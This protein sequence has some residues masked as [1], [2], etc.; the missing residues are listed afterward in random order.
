MTPEQLL[1]LAHRAERFDHVRSEHVLELLKHAEG[2]RRQVDQLRTGL[3]AAKRVMWMAEL[4]ADT[5]SSSERRFYEEADEEV[6]LALTSS[7]EVVP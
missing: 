5:G 3:K 1:E 2:L 4:Y 6:N 7:P